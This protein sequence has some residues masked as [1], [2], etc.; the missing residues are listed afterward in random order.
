MKYRNFGRSDLKVSVIGF[1]CWPMG[2]SQYG[3]TDDNEE[4]TAV[5]KALDAGITCFDTAAGYGLGHSEKLLGRALGARRKDVVVVTKC[6]IAFNPET[7]VFERDSSREHILTS[8]DNSLALLD[9]DYLDLFLIHWPD[10]KTPISESMLALQDL[11][12]AGKIRYAG[13]S[14]FL[15]DRLTEARQTLDIVANQV[16]Y[17]LFDRRIEREV[18]P[19]CD[20]EGIGIMAYGSLAHGMLTGA[21]SADTEFEESDWRATGYAFGLPLFKG[22]HFLANLEAVR[23]LSEIARREGIAIATLA[24]AWVLRKSAVTV[25]LIGFRRPEEIDDALKVT[26]LQL[27]DALLEE[28]DAISLEAFER[29]YADR[30][31]DP[32]DSPPNPDNPNPTRR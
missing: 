1:G 15:P 12:E 13:V 18:M 27:S 22:D 29:L 30:E 16:G 9:T 32:I 6:G 4:V 20:R 11:I 5:H 17:H 23:R 7:S 31:F 24:S 25:S 8:I 14:N 19:H 2:G 26:E 10:P 21:M 3:T 28:I